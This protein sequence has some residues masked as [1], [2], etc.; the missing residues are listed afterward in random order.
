MCPRLEAGSKLL[1][2]RATRPPAQM[3]EIVSESHTQFD[4]I[5]GISRRQ[6]IAG[7]VALS[8]L[9]LGPAALLAADEGIIAAEAIHQE[10]VFKA[11]RRRV[12][13]ALTDEAQ[14]QKV[15]AMS[16]AMKGGM[17]PNA[18]P[19]KISR[20]AGGAFSAFGGYVTGRQIELVG[21]ER[22]VQAWRPAS[23]KPGIFSIARFELVEDAGGGTKIIFDHTGFPK[24]TA[25]HLAA[26]WKANYWEP[27][28]KFL[29]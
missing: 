17:A 15:A 14:F 28:E 27:L 24:G 6:A 21:D 19:T 4:R 18:A 29:S 1:G 2:G 13:D 25:E 23:W 3:E 11:S 9:A 22:I 16:E 5:Y 12:Y 20:D 26:G 7:A 10:P 8:S